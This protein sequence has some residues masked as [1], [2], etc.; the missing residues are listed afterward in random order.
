MNAKSEHMKHI[1]KSKFNIL[2]KLKHK[3]EGHQLTVN[4]TVT[5]FS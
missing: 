3:V 4:K 2:A 1:N 5:F